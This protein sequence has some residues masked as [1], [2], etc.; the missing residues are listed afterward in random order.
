MKRIAVLGSTGSIGKSSLDV[1]G[2]FRDEFCVSGLSAYSNVKLLKE[3]ARLF[4]PD[5]LAINN[6]N[7]ADLRRHLNS[8]TKIFGNQFHRKENQLHQE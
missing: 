5:T 2:G 6:E 4:K 8:G 7:L 3:Q 1:I